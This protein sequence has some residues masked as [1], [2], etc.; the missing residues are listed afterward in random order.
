MNNNTWNQYETNK[1]TP[2]IELLKKISQ[3]FNV[4]LDYLLG[5]I[6]EPYNPH[7]KT[8]QELICIYNS[9]DSDKKKKLIKN[10]LD[11]CKTL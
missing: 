9:L 4:S 1:R 2:N 3:Y 5:T 11:I 10:L 8:F 7:D 6:S